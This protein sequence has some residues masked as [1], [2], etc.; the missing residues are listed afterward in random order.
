MA[1]PTSTP[2]RT[3]SEESTD[4][5]PAMMEKELEAKISAEVAEVRR[6]D[7]K[8]ESNDSRPFLELSTHEQL[9]VAHLES[10]SRL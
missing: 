4:A 1:V 7:P 10:M 9:S 5:F 3:T 2:Q 6:D 8:T